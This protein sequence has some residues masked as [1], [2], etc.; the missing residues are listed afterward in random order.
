VRAGFWALC[1]AS[2]LSAACSGDDDDA[3][4]AGAGASSGAG[5]GNAGRNAGSGGNA[6]AG[7]DGGKSGSGGS[8]GASGATANGGRGG[9]G[10]A[11]AG[12]GAAGGGTGGTGAPS[13]DL[14]QIGGCAIFT[15]ADA[16]NQDISAAAVD[17]AWTARLQALVGDV[18]LHPDYGNSGDEHYGIPI[19]VVPESQPKVDVE[20]D[21]Y[22]EESDQGPYPF[23]GPDQVKIEGG[24][25]EDCDGDCHVLVVQQGACMLYEG[26]ACSYDAGWRCGGEATWD[27]SKDSYGQREEGFTSAD[28]AGLSITAGLVRFDEVQAGELRHAIRFTV[29]CTRDSHIRPASHHAVPG[30]CDAEDPNAPPMGL[31]VRLRADYDVSRLSAPAQVVARAMQTYGMI[32]A[33]NGSNFYF[34]GDDN[35]GWT[36]EQVEPLK[37]IPASAFEV[38]RTPGL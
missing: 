36:E 4:A 9:S 31:R 16:W 19:N 30:G 24:T 38:V 21:Q 18:D 33:D 11:R 37:T 27:L 34:Q 25:A 13:G 10:G 22:P 8:A 28:A 35:P 32:L 26:Y 1:C 29:E 15:A 7:A 3:A 17:D 12:S 5:A 6:G 20:I 2:L 14:P 23:P